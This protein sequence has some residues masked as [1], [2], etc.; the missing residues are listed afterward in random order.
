[1]FS[2]HISFHSIIF[3]MLCPKCMVV[4]TLQLRSAVIVRVRLFDFWNGKRKYY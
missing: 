2:D 1:M 4:K 3:Y